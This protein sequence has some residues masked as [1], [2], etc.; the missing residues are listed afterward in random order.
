MEPLRIVFLGTP[1]FAVPTL[2]CLIDRRE[3]IVAVVTQPDRPVGRG[4]RVAPCP[5]K[6]L[7]LKHGLLV[8][9]PEKV[10]SPEFLAQVK[11]LAPDLAVVAAYGQIFSQQLLDIPTHGFINVH[12][13]LL[14]VYRGPAP[15]NWAIINGDT[16]TG[17]T[18]MKVSLRMDEGDILLQ[19]KVP[20]LPEDDAE[21]L[22]DRLAHL[23]ARLVGQA[24]DLL[25]NNG[26]QPRPQ[27]HSRATYAPM[28][29]KEDG[30][31]DWH[32][33]ALS[34][35]RKIR[36]M[37]PWPGTYTL[38]EGKRLRIHCAKPQPYEGSS[39][40]GTILDVSPD[41]ILVATGRGA[42]LITEVQLE[43]KKRMAAKE[44]L[45]GHALRE[46]MRFTHNV[47]SK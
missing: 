28:L 41:G 34:I 39:E 25:R 22:H 36:G 6:E 47:Q 16:E 10:N 33:D 44:F 13:S 2:Q 7:A 46:G 27:D 5:V 17:V 30:L 42:L 29:K 3:H 26:W 20:I 38:Y 15:I 1:A 12:S 19:E 18:I 40:P 32:K 45:L 23:G 31:I 4:R 35:E 21:S 9:Q 37:K 14:P 24:I 11:S 43:G 8:L